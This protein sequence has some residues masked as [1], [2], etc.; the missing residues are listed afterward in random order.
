MAAEPSPAWFW[1]AAIAGAGWCAGCGLRAAGLAPLLCALG[2]GDSKP[3]WFADKQGEMQPA[4]PSEAG[5]G[6]NEGR[7]ANRAEAS[8]C[9]S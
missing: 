9:A 7:V 3:R 4:I 1:G 2:P 6:E 8:R 5:W